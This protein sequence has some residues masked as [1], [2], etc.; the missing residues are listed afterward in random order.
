MKEDEGGQDWW[1][2]YCYLRDPLIWDEAKSSVWT[3]AEVA[4]EMFIFAEAYDTTRLR[5]DAID[6]LLCCNKL[7][8]AHSDRAGDFL[9]PTSITRAYAQIRP[10]SA[11]RQL[12]VAGYCLLD[13]KSKVV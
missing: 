9:L 5:Q 8:L 13:D 7:S 10:G 12:L 1:V 4:I 3:Y 6:R 2:P 11:L